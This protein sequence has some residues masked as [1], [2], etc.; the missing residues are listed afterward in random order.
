MNIQIFDE[1]FIR[2][3]NI[4]INDI[5]KSMMSLDTSQLQDGSMNCMVQSKRDH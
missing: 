2:S 4:K 5:I 3:I 1:E